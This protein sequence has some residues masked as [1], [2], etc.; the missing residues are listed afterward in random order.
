MNDT[1]PNLECGDL[2]PLFHVDDS[3]STIARQVAPPE[4]GDKSQHPKSPWPHAPVHKLTEHGVYIVTA[5]TLYKQRCFDAGEKLS[6]LQLKLFDLAN[7]Y[8]WQLE[9][10]A[11]FPNHYH[12]V[13]RGCPESQNLRKLITHLHSDSAREL[14]RI[15]AAAGRKVW[16]NFWD[17]KL[18]FETSY[19]ARLNYVHQNAV[20]HGLVAVANQYRWCSAAWFE[21]VA[22]PA[23]VQTIY[24]SR[25]T[26]CRCRMISDS[27]PIPYAVAWFRDRSRNKKAATSRSTPGRTC[28]A[29]A[30]WSAV[31]CHRF[32]LRRLVA[33]EPR[34]DRRLWDGREWLSGSTKVSP[35]VAPLNVCDNPLRPG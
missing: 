30:P 18:T 2:S 14:N 6:L 5:G 32:F 23:M 24:S 10:W 26:K 17:T 27:R 33:E 35:R 4:G 28:G 9:A 12:F 31:T 20:R 1:Q 21:R 8:H 11:M 16:S 29:A 15:D 19:L 25:P 22:T 3:S 7:K 34:C 13:A